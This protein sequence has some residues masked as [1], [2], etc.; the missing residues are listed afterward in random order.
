MLPRPAFFLGIASLAVCAVLNPARAQSPKDKGDLLDQTRRER[1]VDAQKAESD[2]RAT[3]QAA[4]K[5][6]VKDPAKALEI[7]KATAAKLD[8][9]AE[10]SEARRAVLKRVFADR[11]RVAEAMLDQ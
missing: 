4:E 3:L 5:L 1:E 6:A 7:L 2:I 10:L 9:Y 11:V 8:D